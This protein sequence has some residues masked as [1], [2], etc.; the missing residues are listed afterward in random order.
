MFSFLVVDAKEGEIVWT[1]AMKI[2]SNTKHH[3]IKCLILQVVFEREMC[4][5]AISKYFGD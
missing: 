2:V 4:P 5:W 1:K 3:Q